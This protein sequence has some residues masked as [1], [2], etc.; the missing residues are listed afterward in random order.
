VTGDADDPWRQLDPHDDSSA[1]IKPAKKGVT[2]R[3]PIALATDPVP[4]DS[5]TAV[6][7]QSF[8]DVLHTPATSSIQAMAAKLQG[9]GKGWLKLPYF[10]EF[11]P[12]FAEQTSAKVKLARR[13][14]ARARKLN[15]TNQVQTGR[16]PINQCICPLIVFWRVCA[17]YTGIR[18]IEYDVQSFGV[19][20]FDR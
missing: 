16:V 19:F 6:A 4:S 14:R 3:Q 17:A 15:T 5:N 11:L 8:L 9:G 12:Y 10:Q 2:Y 1:K 7:V 20:S 18:S 13:T